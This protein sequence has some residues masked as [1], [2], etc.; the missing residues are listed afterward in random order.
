MAEE[1]TTV[2]QLIQDIVDK[3]T[4]KREDIAYQLRQAGFGCCIATLHKWANGVGPA[5]NS[6][7]AIA[8]ALRKIQKAAPKKKKGASK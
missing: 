6:T 4:L 5:K 7:G 3:T 1:M 8:Q 2:Q